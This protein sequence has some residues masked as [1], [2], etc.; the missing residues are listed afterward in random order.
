MKKEV[1]K[2]EKYSFSDPFGTVTAS[3]SMIYLD[4]EGFLDDTEIERLSALTATQFDELN[5]VSIKSGQRTLTKDELYHCL[6]FFR[7]Q[8][9]DLANL[10]GIDKSVVSRQLKGKSSIT[11]A[12]SSTLIDLIVNELA[13]KGYVQRKVRAL[14]AAIQNNNSLE[15]LGVEPKSVALLLISKFK[16]HKAEIT[17]LKLHKLLYYAHGLGI[18]LYNVKLFDEP[19]LAYKMGPV[20][21][22]TYK[23]T[24]KY[25]SDDLAKLLP[26]DRE[27][28][29]PS[30][31]VRD[32]VDATFER[33]GKVET[34]ALVEAT[35]KEK[36]W[37]QTKQ[38]AEISDELMIQEFR[39]K[40][41]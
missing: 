17:K 18:A 4:G 11:T 10:L 13:E 21:E 6:V 20:L 27:I 33:Y 15:E 31:V 30:E 9:N 14:K 16:Q 8:A 34:W 37:T 25:K 3:V 1:K 29:E 38:S 7:I 36:P 22:S 26:D 40:Y 32:I 2:I 28:I 19:F 5:R 39:G 24:K 35:H 12:Q 23:L 41:L